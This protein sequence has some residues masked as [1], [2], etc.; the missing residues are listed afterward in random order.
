MAQNPGLP[1][2]LDIVIRN[3]PN[4]EDYDVAAGNTQLLAALGVVDAD[5]AKVHKQ[6]I[7]SALKHSGYSIDMIKITSGPAVKVWEC[8]TSVQ[9]NAEQLQ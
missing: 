8:W 7:H 3:T 5:Q 6:G 4:P 2:F 9:N 1:F